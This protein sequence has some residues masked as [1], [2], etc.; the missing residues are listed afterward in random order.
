MEKFRCPDQSV[1]LQ[2]LSPGLSPVNADQTA[3]QFGWILT[4]SHVNFTFP[5]KHGT[6]I[7]INHKRQVK[8]CVQSN[9]HEVSHILFYSACKRATLEEMEIMQ[10]DPA[11]SS[12]FHC[13]KIDIPLYDPKDIVC[14]ADPPGLFFTLIV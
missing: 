12:K 11:D 5:S 7:F 4:E 1:S 10:E 14:T 9:C 2:L 6:F 13:S 8:S 3:I